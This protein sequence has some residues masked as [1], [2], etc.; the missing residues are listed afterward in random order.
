MMP[1]SPPLTPTEIFEYVI[2]A[3]QSFASSSGGAADSLCQ[4]PATILVTA[5]GGAAG[6]PPHS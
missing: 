5:V 3:F 2:Q 6:P 4:A 1:S